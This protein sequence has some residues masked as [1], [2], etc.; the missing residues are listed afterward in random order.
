MLL[1]LVAMWVP[2]EGVHSHIFVQDF[3]TQQ[4]GGAFNAFPLHFDVVSVVSG[5]ASQ[6]EGEAPALHGRGA[7]PGEMARP[8]GGRGGAGQSMP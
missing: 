5:G 8:L 2:S 6:E 4:P 3:S 1:R 7:A